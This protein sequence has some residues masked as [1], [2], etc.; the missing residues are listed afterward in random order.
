[1]PLLDW[2]AEF[3]TGIDY[4]DYEHRR[5]VESINRICKALTQP[6][7]EE[8]VSDCLGQLYAQISAHFTVE[9]HLMRENKYDLYDVHKGDHEKLLEEVRYM[10]DAYEAGA[11]ETCGKT[12]DECLTEWFYKHF[13]TKDARFETLRA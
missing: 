9:E 4:V 7:S 5:L 11:C 2:K 10:M 13:R 6:E 3:E 12:L 1:M 8:A